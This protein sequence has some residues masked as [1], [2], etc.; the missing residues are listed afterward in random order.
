[1]A[2]VNKTNRQRFE[3]NLLNIRLTQYKKELKM[4]ASRRPLHQ[5]EINL[6]GHI[7][8]KISRIE[9]HLGLT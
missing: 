9:S 4:L 2:H 6:I 8:V 7:N 5:H 3:Y 1:M